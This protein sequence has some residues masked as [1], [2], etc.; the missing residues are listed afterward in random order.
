[1][2]K[3]ILVEKAALLSS[4]FLLIGLLMTMIGT[5][6]LSA[7]ELATSRG[8]SYW[9]I[10]AGLILLVIGVLWIVKFN[11]NIKKFQ[12]LLQEKSKAVFLKNLDEIE[13]LAWRLPS[14]YGK[15]LV[16]KKKEFNVK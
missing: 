4:A 1:M 9:L 6:I 3:P 15:E 5:Y 12:S 7:E 10:F 13:Y 8:W 11:L 14:T 16:S 2:A